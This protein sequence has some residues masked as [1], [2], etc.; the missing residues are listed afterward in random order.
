[1]QFSTKQKVTSLVKK[2]GLFQ[3]ELIKPQA[4]CSTKNLSNDS[5]IKFL[6]RR[7]NVDYY[8]FI[9]YVLLIV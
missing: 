1:M 6:L 8:N 2:P 3:K 9:K 7:L 5:I 4:F